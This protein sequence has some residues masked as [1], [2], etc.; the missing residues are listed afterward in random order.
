ME[1]QKSTFIIRREDR[2]VDPVTLITDGLRIGRLPECE[3]V[4]NHPTVSRI[5]AGINKVEGR[6]YLISLSQSNSTTLNE[7]LIPSEEAE[8]LAEGDVVQIGPFFLQIAQAAEALEIRVTE[9]VASNIGDTLSRIDTKSLAKQREA[10]ATAAAHREIAG[11]L[12]IFWEKRTRAKAARPSPLHP[13]QPPRP[14]KVRFNWTP[15]R[16]LVRP[17]PFS[18][19]V[20]AAITVVVLSILATVAYTPVYSPAPVSRAHASSTLSLMP[21]IARQA[22][23]GSCTQCHAV[24]TSMETNCSSC[25]QTNAFVASVIPQHEKAGVGCT[26]CHAEHQGADFRPGEAALKACAACH[27]NN[28]RGIY[29][30]P[31]L[32]APHGGKLFGYPVQVVGNSHQWVWKGLDEEELAQKPEI[33]RLHEPCDAEHAARRQPCDSEQQWRSKQFHALHLYRVRAINGIT[34]IADKEGADRVLSC[35][36]CHQSFAPI[37]RDSPKETCAKCHN[38]QVA[39]RV[40]SNLIE[41]SAPNCASCHVQHVKD[42]RHWNPN[43]L[44]PAAR[45]SSGREGRSHL[46]S[47]VIR[48][49]WAGE[50]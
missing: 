45:A 17:W 20:W 25:H 27:S 12:K 8:P 3:L 41:A 14:G 24:Q 35:S 16:D 4:L 6:F 39:G 26:A 22:N 44:V 13:R 19:F 9:Q 49:L 5:H 15:T 33:A 47:I 11:A 1:Q 32:S 31:R 48:R 28:N 34:G 38:N 21:A 2:A 46:I 37:D 29:Q 18:I 10:P 50:A 43:L 36:S 40:Q 23:A 42:K 7:R 30:G